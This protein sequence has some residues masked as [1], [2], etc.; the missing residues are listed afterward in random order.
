MSDSL[1][2]V[3]RYRLQELIGRGGM[4][5]VYKAWDPNTQRHVAIKIMHQHLAEQPG[6]QA[7][8]SQ[9]GT[10]IA[11][12]QHPNIVPIFDFD[13]QEN[14]SG[15]MHYM[16]MP[17][18]SG[19]SLKERN[20]TLAASGERMTLDEIERIMAGVAAALDYAHAKGMVH[21]DI[22]PANILFNERGE[23]ML[24]DFGLARLKDTARLTRSGFT[25]GTPAYMSPEQGR[26][27]AGDARSDVYSLGVILYELLAGELPYQADTELGVI[28]KHINEPLPWLSGIVPDVPAGV[29]AVVYRALAKQP[30][31]RYQQAGDLAAE[32][33]VAIAGE[34][35]SRETRKA[36]RRRNGGRPRLL[37]ALGGIAAAVIVALLVLALRPA[38]APPQPT[39]TEP[40][41]SMAGGPVPFDTGFGPDDEYNVGWPL[42]EGVVTRAIVDGFYRFSSR[43]PGQAHTAIFEPDFYQYSTA[44][45]ETTATLTEASQPDS[46]FGLV[47]RYQDE[48]NYYVFAINGRQQVSIWVRE[49]GVWRELRGGADDWTVNEVVNPPGEPNLLSVFVHGDTITGSVNG[50]RVVSVTD[51]TITAGG[52]G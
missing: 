14:T 44:I 46:G 19:P 43:A 51:D 48:D 34:A 25:T 42:S 29:E 13:Q 50:S 38:A 16:V 49:A 9:E 18:I 12:L 28:L 33:S 36:A 47:F 15:M 45:I 30:D 39:A 52:V 3:G 8:F 4:A 35:V 40:A 20:E 23:P 7:R 5:Q 1:G 24:T 10:L 32:L 26:G 11:R 21:R 37:L 31:D 41:S 17:Y 2:S 6:F 22:K 27:D